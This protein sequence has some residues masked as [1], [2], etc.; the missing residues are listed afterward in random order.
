VSVSNSDLDPD[1]IVNLLVNLMESRL[2]DF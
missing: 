1:P 2:P